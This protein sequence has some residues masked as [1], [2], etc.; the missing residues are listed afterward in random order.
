MHEIAQIGED[1]VDLIVGRKTDPDKVAVWA[2]SNCYHRRME[3]AKELMAAGLKVD[4]FGRCFGG[5]Q[6]GGGTYSTSFYDEI[7]RYKFY[8]SFENSITCKDYITEKFWFNGLRAG[9]VPVV[10]GP[11]KEDVLEVHCELVVIRFYSCLNLSYF[12]FR[13]ES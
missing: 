5:R 9:A 4:T 10:W 11:S 12:N 3:Y 6:I 13:L 1:D 2:V 7:S 8:L